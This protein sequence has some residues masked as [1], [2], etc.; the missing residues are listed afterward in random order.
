MN[1]IIK[2][3]NSENPDAVTIKEAA[4]IIQA[5]G[6]VAFPTETVYGL[7]A[8]ALDEAS[9]KKI[10]QAKGRPSD[11]PLIVHISSREELPPLVEY[12]P[13]KAQILMDAFWPGPL[14]LIFP[15]SD[16]IPYSITAGLATVA[17]RLPQNK[18][19]RALI[20]AAQVPIAAPS[21][22]TSGKPSP[23]KA[24]HVIED[25][26]GKIEMILDG[27]SVLVG[28]ESTVVDVTGD[29][30]MILR[31]G[32]VTKEMLEEAVG[33]VLVDPAIL[34]QKALT[35]IPKSPGMKYKHYAP[36]AKVTIVDG[37][38]SKV[39]DTIN[40]FTIEKHAQ[41][42]KVGIMATTQTKDSYRGDCIIVVGDR[43]QPETIAANLF[44]TL[45]AFDEAGMDV[46]L[47]EAFP[48]EEIGFAIMNRLQKAAGYD[49][50]RV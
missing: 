3:L 46:I 19:A 43:N 28:L 23:T 34:S 7:G 50:V 45:R 39:I 31:P 27:G 24:S 16:S 18:I 11:N 47:A 10:F 2:A 17:I 25:L 38:L 21:A 22:N 30:P 5:G 37:E 26:N 4:Q 49:I 42:L 9:V 29:I 15:K 40:K 44:D 33:E 20:E 13:E 36:K 1:T 32:G 41:H 48:Y 35:S 6:L 12:I 8:N 14:T